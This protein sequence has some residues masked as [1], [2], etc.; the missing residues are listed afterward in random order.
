MPRESKSRKIDDLMTMASDA[1][2]KT[3]Y[4]EAERLASK[5][6]IYAFQA[7]DFEQMARI[8]LPSSS[9]KSE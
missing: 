5:A 8:L 4:F 6:L 3:E 1:L 2:S 7:S 9:K